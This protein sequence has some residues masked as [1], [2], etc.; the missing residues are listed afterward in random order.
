M[1]A[2]YLYI[3]IYVTV[4][5]NNNANLIPVVLFTSNMIEWFL[6][7]NVSTYIIYKQL[8]NN[9]RTKHS[10]ASQEDSPKQEVS[11][12]DRLIQ[13]VLKGVL[14]ESCVEYCQQ[15]A[16]G[17]DSATIAYVSLLQDTGFSEADLSL[18]AWLQ[19]IPYDTFGCPFE[20]K[21]RL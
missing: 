16:T 20:Q 9:K 21:V 2:G 14:Y 8:F 17:A 10:S 11:R 4:I 1:S 15:A 13:L 3:Y 18:L 6:L 12:S 19:S 7:C 5:I